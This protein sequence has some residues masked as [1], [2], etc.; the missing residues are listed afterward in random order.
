LKSAVIVEP[1]THPLDESLE[2]FK[3]DYDAAQEMADLSPDDK[4]RLIQ[5]SFDALGQKVIETIKVP[6]VAKE[7]SLSMIWLKRFLKHYNL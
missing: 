4:L 5:Q 2:K 6:Q 7:P 1:P 3:S